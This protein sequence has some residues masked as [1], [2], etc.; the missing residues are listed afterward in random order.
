MPFESKYTMDDK[1]EVCNW[2]T[3]KGGNSISVMK[4][5][6]VPAQ[7]IRGW[8]KTD[9]WAEMQ[10]DIRKKHASRFDGKMT[11]VMDA[12]MKALM[13]RVEHG[14]EVLWAKTGE[15]I[16]KAMSGR[17]LSTA[18]N[19]VIEK[20]ALLRGDATSR[21]SAISTEKQM[22]NLQKKMEDR[23]KEHK[24]KQQQAIDEAD[25]VKEIRKKQ[26]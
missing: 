2:M 12:M 16:K 22:E 6:G 8:T 19:Q 9:W 20:R 10:A 14:D 18:L 15:M 24:A 1:R 11:Y 13:D 5:T 17:D 7:T 4:R 3:I 26:A 21:S 23:V 25:N